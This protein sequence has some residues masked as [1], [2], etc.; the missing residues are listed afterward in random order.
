MSSESAP[1]PGKVSRR[2]LALA[3]IVAGLVVVFVVVNGMSSRNA[4]EAKLK[5]TTDAQAVPTVAVIQP[6]LGGN[7]SSLDLPGRLEA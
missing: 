3:G 1:A 2:S 4:S 7:K 5:E 6:G